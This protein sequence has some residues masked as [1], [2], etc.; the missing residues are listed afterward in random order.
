VPQFL[1]EILEEISSIART[2]P[3]INQQSGV[4]VRMSIA[5][6]ENV[7]SN[8]ERRGLLL[9][10]VPAVPRI[11]DLAYLAAST[12]G[13]IELTLT[14][15]EGQEDQIIAKLMGEAVKNVF[16]SHFEPKHL[17]PLVEWFEGGKT[18]V[19]GDRL[20]SADYGRRLSEAPLLKKEVARFLERPEMQEIAG[21]APD[22]ATASAV[23]FILEGRRRGP[24][25]LA[26]PGSH[27]QRLAFLL[28]ELDVMRNVV[29][30]SGEQ[31]LQRERA[32]LVVHAD[33][34]QR[35]VRQGAQDAG[36]LAARPFHDRQLLLQIAAVVVQRRGETVF[37][38]AEQG[39][40]VLGDDPLHAVGVDGVEVRQVADDLERAPLARDGA[41]QQL[42]ARHAGHRLAKL[43]RAGEVGFGELCDLCHG[44]DLHPLAA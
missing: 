6:L 8:A 35:L 18:F 7:I 36:E 42:L 39:R 28:D 21:M 30:R 14:E 9:G 38:G 1:K 20:S 34:L 25:P 5:N 4:S 10:E 15:D 19:T 16:E 2:S 41:R 27:P 13:K 17:R 43:P 24:P 33:A 44:D 31:L 11:S 3:A 29:G 32:A 22:A 37:V 26:S 40:L 23:E 12:R